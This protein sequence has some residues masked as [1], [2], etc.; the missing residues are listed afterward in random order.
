VAIYGVGYITT[1]CKRFWPTFCKDKASSSLITSDFGLHL[2]LHRVHNQG[3]SLRPCTLSLDEMPR[4]PR[5]MTPESW[6]RPWPTG[7]LTWAITG[8]TIACLPKAA[9][10][11]I[12][13]KEASFKPLPDFP[14]SAPS[15]YGRPYV[16]CLA[17]TRQHP[18]RVGV[19]DPFP[20]SVRIRMHKL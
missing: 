4:A 19:I 18:N 9:S 2:I 5:S 8:G 11:D 13:K 6:M 1:T 12:P 7:L 15:L 3:Q 10:S 20:T 14:S 16:P 17:N